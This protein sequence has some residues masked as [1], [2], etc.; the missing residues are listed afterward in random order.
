LKRRIVIVGFLLHALMLTVMYIVQSFVF[1]YL[2][3]TGIR[4]LLLPLGV[5]GVAVFEGSTRGGLFG[6]FAGM[7]CDISFNQPIAVLTVLFTMFG[8]AAGFLADII[9]ARGFPS[10][11]ACCIAI[12]AMTAFTQ[13]FTLLFFEKIPAYALLNTA[14]L[15]I[16]HSLVFAIPVYFAAKALGYR[17]LDRRREF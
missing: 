11:I 6:L 3:P 14:A 15:Q 7:M 13:M 9:M 1:T 2:P 12:L 4:P 17:G 10:Y 8:L 5:A 16:L